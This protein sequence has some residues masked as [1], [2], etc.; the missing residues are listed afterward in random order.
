[1][2]AMTFLWE[3]LQTKNYKLMSLPKTQGFVHAGNIHVYLMHGC[4]ENASSLLINTPNGLKEV[5][6]TMQRFATCIKRGG[7]RKNI[8]S[9]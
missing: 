3:L 1:M 6:K 8:S 7:T 5:V 4:S 2:A 9:A